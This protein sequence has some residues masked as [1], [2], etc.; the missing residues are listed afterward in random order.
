[1]TER[2]HEFGIR[3]AIGADPS[4]IM[5]CVLRQA[6]I[7][8]ATGLVAGLA[9]AWILGRVVESRLFGITSRDPAIYTAAAFTMV[10]VIAVATFIP[11]RAATRVNPVDMLKQE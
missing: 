10:L 6:A 8:G 5:R 4:Q 1:M 2:R 11:A 7:L 9:L 3:L